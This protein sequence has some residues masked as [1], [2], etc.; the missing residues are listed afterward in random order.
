M[1]F[2]PKLHRPYTIFVQITPVL[3]TR[4]FWFQKL[5]CL[6]IC[7]D[8]SSARSNLMSL[9]TLIVSRSKVMWFSTADGSDLQQTTG[10]LSCRVC[11]DFT[12]F[13]SK[14]LQHQLDAFSQAY[15]LSLLEYRGK[16]NSFKFEACLAYITSFRP[17]QYT[18]WG[19]VSKIKE[20]KDGN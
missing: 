18:Q 20:R 9:S 8:I 19:D 12:S 3:K 4:Y 17:D 2:K 13:S 14:E 5:D 1:D 6:H 16:W 7:A 10:N 11:Q 15:S